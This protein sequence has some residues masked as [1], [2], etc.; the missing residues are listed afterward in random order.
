MNAIDH[1]LFD[2]IAVAASTTPTG[3]VWEFCHGLES[4]SPEASEDELRTRARQVTQTAA[5]DRFLE[6]ITAW[7][8]SQRPLS[9]VVLSQA[10]LAA[11]ITAER[12][13]TRQ[14][15]ELVW[16]GPAVPQSTIRSTDQVLLEL[17]NTA[18]SEILIVT[19]VAY[20]IP[21]VQSALLRAANRGV[22]ITI[23]VESP[24]VSKGK[25]AFSALEAIGT[26]VA[27]QSRVYVWP[28]EARGTDDEGHY[29]SLHVKC[30]VADGFMALVSSAN[31]TKFALNLNM[32]LGVLVR[33]GSLPGEV[34]GHFA[35]LIHE[36]VLTAV[37][38]CQPILEMGR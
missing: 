35:T 5:R 7:K 3:V 30:A 11:S 10:L 31:L 32:E 33:G 16:T 29:G 24:D 36:G 37:D 38:D 17:I 19:F 8:Q 27:K 28:T 22:R 4:L 13:R 20:D 23:V 26:T 15:V 18:N 2:A 1:E 9:P 34:A 12:Y 25:V 21:D 14:S 6:A